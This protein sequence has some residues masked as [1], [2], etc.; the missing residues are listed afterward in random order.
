M[1]QNFLPLNQEIG[2]P[3]W[4]LDPN[5]GFDP[6]P[7]EL[8]RSQ[9]DSEDAGSRLKGLENINYLWC[10]EP[11]EKAVRKGRGGEEEKEKCAREDFSCAFYTNTLNHTEFFSL[12]Y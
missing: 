11:R 10:M 12:Y 5:S 3:S 4:Q 2:D 8:H 7:A 1:L 6:V 9:P